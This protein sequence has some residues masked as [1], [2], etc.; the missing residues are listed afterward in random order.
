MRAACTT[1]AT[2]RG[3]AASNLRR[4]LPLGRRSPACAAAARPCS[5]A[6]APAHPQQRRQQAPRG[7]A[8]HR[9]A[10]GD[11]QGPTR[12]GGDDDGGEPPQRD[13]VIPIAVGLSVLAYMGVAAVAWWQAYGPE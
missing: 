5:P 11:R 12:G 4:P 13:L 7:G 8:R 10:G 1:P 9:A 3:A 6:P 2:S